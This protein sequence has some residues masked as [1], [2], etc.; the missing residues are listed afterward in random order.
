MTN[1]RVIRSSIVL[2]GMFVLMQSAYAIRG[3]A[4]SRRLDICCAG[5]NDCP[6]GSACQSGSE[7][8]SDEWEG[9]CIDITAD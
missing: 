8:C 1:S 7:K 6:S 3:S 9:F 4:A 2:L 5:S